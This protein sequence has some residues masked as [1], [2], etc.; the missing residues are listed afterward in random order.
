MNFFIKYRLQINI[1]LLLIWL[2]VLIDNI[3][4]NEISWTKLTIPILFITMSLF[5]IYKVFK[6]KQ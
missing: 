1:V 4:L 2:Y 5:N 3:R 6:P